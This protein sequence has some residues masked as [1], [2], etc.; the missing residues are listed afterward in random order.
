[1]VQTTVWQA[2]GSEWGRMAGTSL[3]PWMQSR[4]EGRWNGTGVP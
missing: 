2:E 3:A 1:M 4:G